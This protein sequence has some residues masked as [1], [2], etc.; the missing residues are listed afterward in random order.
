MKR[1]IETTDDY[2]V[3]V[4]SSVYTGREPFLADHV[5]QGTKILPGMA[6]LEIARAAV[7]A[8]VEIGEDFFLVL[9]DS[10]FINALTVEQ[11][12]TVE[13]RVYP[14][15]SAEF[16]VEVVTGKGVHFQTKVYV[17]EKARG[18]DHVR[19]DLAS[20]MQQCD[21]PG[22]DRQSFYDTFRK[23]GVELGPT[24]RGVQ[25][26]RLGEGC[27]LGTISLPG[28]SA[29]GMAMDPGMLDCVIQCGFVLAEDPE[30]DVV[31]F[32]VKEAR[33]YA[34]LADD[35]QVYVSR[36]GTGLDYLGADAHGQVRIQITGFMTREINLRVATSELAYFRPRLVTVLPPVRDGR[37][38]EL[39]EASESY[40]ETV[41]RILE[42]AMRL[43]SGK[44]GSSLLEIEVGEHGLGQIHG[45]LAALKSVRQEHPGIDFSLRQANECKDIVLSE[46]VLAS[47]AEFEW[48][49]NHT[50]LIVGGSGGLGRLV[51]QDIATRTSG[52]RLILLGRSPAGPRIAE[53]CASLE[54]LG[55]RVVHEVCDVADRSQVDALV[56]RYDEIHGVIH[57]AG[58]LHDGLLVDKVEDDVLQVLAPKVAG[59]KN[60][61]EA[62]AD[63]MLDYLVVFS[64]V[65]GALGNA[66][67]FDYA[68]ANGYMDGYMR[69]RAD[70]VARG[71]RSGRSLSVNWPLW[72]SGG[73]Q[74][75]QARIDNL[76]RMFR[77]R[78][79]PTEAGLKALKTLMGSNESQAV[80]LFGEKPGMA[81]MMAMDKPEPRQRTRPEEDRAGGEKLLREIAREVRNT[82]GQHLKRNPDQLDD[83]A[84]WAEFGFDS[85]LLSS[86]ANRFNSRFELNLMPMVMFEATN[87]KLLAEYLA[88][89]HRAEMERALAPDSN[90]ERSDEPS[91]NR[92]P[93]VADP[94][95]DSSADGFSRGFR[96]R[97]RTHRAYRDKDIAIVGMSCRI[98]GA[99][100]LD[101][102]WQVLSGERDM[103]S[104]IPSDRWN[105]RDYP[106][107]SKW[108]SF[109]DGVAEFD[110]LFFGIS[111]A[112]AMYMA[113]EQRL[114][115]Q[116]VWECLEDAGCGGESIRGTNTA[117]F[118]GCGLS[119]YQSLLS[120]LPVEAYSATGMVPSVGPNRIS[121]M[122]DWHGPSNPVDTA[123]SS[124]LVA[125]HRAVEAIRAG[126]C[127]QAIAG[128]VNL[129]LT[130]D[131][132]ISFSKAGMLCE[133]GR[134][135]TFSNKA[136]G[137]VRGEGVGMFMLKP[138]PAA[139]EDGNVIYA[140][141]KGT[142]ENHGGRTNSLTAPNPKSQASVIKKAFA[143]A[144][145]DF[146]RVGYI[147][148][149]GT[150]TELG[151]PIEI[152]GLKITARDLLADTSTNGNC[153]LGSIK[154]NIGHLEY[155]AGAAG[156][157]KAILQ[158]RHKRIV[159]SL[160]CEQLSPYVDLSGTPFVIAQESRDWDVG[161]RETRVAG[162]SSF[163]FGGVNAHIVLEEY[164]SPEVA[165]P[166]KAK[167][168]ESTPRIV[169][170]SARDEERLNEYVAR[171]VSH[172]DSTAATSDTLASIAYTLQ[173]G[174]AEMA[175]RLAFVVDSI[176][177]L[178]A[179][180]SNYV[181][182]G[183]TD[184]SGKAFKGR[185]E[186]NSAGSSEVGDTDAGRAYIRQLIRNNELS[187]VAELW[188]SGSRIHWD[189]LYEMG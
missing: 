16:G 153:Y 177:D 166:N 134:C 36:A 99:R 56:A 180:T 162:V 91:V 54:A 118:I 147:E 102:A 89:N 164:V 115:M 186:M 148:C 173:T 50:V 37:Q 168:P 126:H 98:A 7:A 48:K 149:H 67:Q 44:S 25:G 133:D 40:P 114:M 104:E 65:A 129:L 1:V 105:W 145:V 174:R 55:C 85:I 150:G 154:S 15:Q 106:E 49:D 90:K 94:E 117:L 59:L 175:E 32:A 103:I 93:A 127:D 73:M 84:D 80:V 14:G 169:V 82:T 185:K 38:S 60:L 30:A 142:A 113:P 77:V 20:L 86:L 81:S 5:I 74:L 83:Q 88:T 9:R 140:V 47:A 17:E 68:A 92:T 125:V 171:L 101:E 45:A 78:P 176:E 156:L 43:G 152:Q 13:V 160:H 29:R 183:S 112:E 21:K 110:P 158:I 179:Q 161:A 26:V 189:Q 165:A 27:A 143:D 18:S 69:E 132:Y 51:A 24:H 66:G 119:G 53:F 62:T 8:S 33:I 122:L 100:T 41:L 172:L 96:R 11:P 131:V 108:G 144:D 135:K 58:C 46:T 109:I 138:L 2:P 4:F 128:G 182:L 157:M 139:I 87:I 57:A 61:D 137:Y 188:V 155:A 39:I 167:D 19:V 178:R 72:E 22:P 95:E 71:Q 121:Y 64:S 35:M 10:V 6:Y 184:Q 3:G 159:K 31:P 76:Y 170:F 136:N 141:V 107:C 130:P 163:G 23:R 97:Y 151:D 79:M 146:G 75:D 120:T 12:C 181:E 28:S 123:C 34:P 42:A 111:P 52:C 187:K 116:Y 124:T 70:A 63:R